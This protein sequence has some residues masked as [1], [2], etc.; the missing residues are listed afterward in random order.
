VA[1]GSDEQ[2]FASALRDGDPDP[3]AELFDRYA[4]R[5]YNGLTR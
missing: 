5:I 2:A 4:D 1:T 3:L